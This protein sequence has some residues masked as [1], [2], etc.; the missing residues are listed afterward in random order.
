MYNCIW[1][2]EWTVCFLSMIWKAKYY[3]HQAMG[4][5]IVIAA[6][7]LFFPSHLRFY[8]D[9]WQIVFK[10]LLHLLLLCGSKPNSILWRSLK[11]IKWVNNDGNSYIQTYLKALVR[12]IYTHVLSCVIKRQVVLCSTKHLLSALLTHICVVQFQSCCK[13]FFL[14]VH[15]AGCR[16]ATIK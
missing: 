8:L 10:H 9:C 3:Y 2:C 7:Q 12:W 6:M 4:G 11:Y 15:F 14:F 13:D 5:G 1:V 16:A